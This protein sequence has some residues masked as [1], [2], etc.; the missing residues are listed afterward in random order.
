MLRRSIQAS[1]GAYRR[2]LRNAGATVSR[3]DFRWG[4]KKCAGDERHRR[5][6]GSRG[7]ACRRGGDRR[8]ARREPEGIEKDS[9]IPGR[10]KRQAPAP[11]WGSK[12]VDRAYDI[13]GRNTVSARAF[14]RQARKVASRRDRRL[15]EVPRR[16][17]SIRTSQGDERRN[18]RGRSWAR[19]GQ[20][21][22]APGPLAARG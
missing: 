13:R 7:R 21:P 3:R 15:R 4:K 2:A 1:G 22:R 12:G 20:R 10:R 9:P 16:E 5:C 11:A 8:E 14:R 6:D 17:D 19:T 18:R